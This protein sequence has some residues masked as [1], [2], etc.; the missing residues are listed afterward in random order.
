M[1]ESLWLFRLHHDGMWKRKCGANK[2][3]LLQERVTTHKTLGLCGPFWLRRFQWN[4][5]SCGRFTLSGFCI[6]L[7]A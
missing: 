6:F 3:L 7:W 1:N 4:D 2:T 5:S